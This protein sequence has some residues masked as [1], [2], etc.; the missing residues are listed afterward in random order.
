MQQVGE[1]QTG[2]VR[3]ASNDPDLERGK[4]SDIGNIRPHADN[5]HRED[6][7]VA[8]RSGPNKRH[9][10]DHWKWLTKFGIN[11]G[12]TNIS[13]GTACIG[14]GVR[15]YVLSANVHQHCK[16]WNC[17]WFPDNNLIESYLSSMLTGNL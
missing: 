7:V 2:D 16:I 11:S 12:C 3:D 8:G 14:M 4:G 15:G 6:M 5:N 1:T 13:F 9:L 10:K 17:G